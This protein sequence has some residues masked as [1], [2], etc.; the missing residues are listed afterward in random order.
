M[1]RGIQARGELPPGARP[2]VL[3]AFDVKANTEAGAAKLVGDG[4]RTRGYTIRSVNRST[5][6]EFLA[7]VSDPTD[8]QSRPNAGV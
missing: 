8:L 6:N 5:G 1:I 4:L 2:K 3:A 7:Y